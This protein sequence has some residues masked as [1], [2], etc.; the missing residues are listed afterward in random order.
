MVILPRRWQ[1]R[2]DERAARKPPPS[3]EHRPADED[4]DADEQE[5]HEDEEQCHDH[6]EASLLAR[7]GDGRR[8]FGGDEK[9]PGS[10]P[11]G[12]SLREAAWKK[13]GGQTPAAR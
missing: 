9:A 3:F 11:Q 10:L 6:D 2:D 13:P 1:G 5:Q 12:L 4:A 8:D 7:G